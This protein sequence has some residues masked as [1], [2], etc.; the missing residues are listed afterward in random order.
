MPADMVAQIVLLDPSGATQDLLALHIDLASVM[1]AGHWETNRMPGE[2]VMAAR[3]WR[4]SGRAGLGLEWLGPAPDHPLWRA[5][6]H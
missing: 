1:Q 5:V 3:R 4:G 6:I 2:H